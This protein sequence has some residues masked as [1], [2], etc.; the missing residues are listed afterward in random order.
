M[1]IPTTT[2]SGI[3]PKTLTFPQARRGGAGAIVTEAAGEGTPFDLTAQY[4]QLQDR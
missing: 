4:L 1:L 2:A 3:T